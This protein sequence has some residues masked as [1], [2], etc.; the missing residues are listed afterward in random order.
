MEPSHSCC[1]HTVTAANIKCERNINLCCC[2]TVCYYSVTERTLTDTPASCHY[3]QTGCGPNDTHHTASHYFLCPWCCSVRLSPYLL[4]LLFFT[5]MAFSES[6]M[7]SSG[8]SSTRCPLQGTHGLGPS[9]MSLISCVWLHRWIHQGEL[10]ES[11]S[12]SVSPT[13]LQRAGIL[14]NLWPSVTSGSGLAHKADLQNELSPSH[15]H[16]S[17]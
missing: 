6:S 3:L 17:L 11:A 13:R 7:L 4:L 15:R 12:V 16:F 10:K 14:S 5:R 8:I 9:L 1:G 2:E